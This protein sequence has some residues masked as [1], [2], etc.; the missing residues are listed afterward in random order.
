MKTT[1]ACFMAVGLGVVALACYARRP[2]EHPAADTSAAKAA[3]PITPVVAG[4]AVKPPA[5]LATA[6]VERGNLICT[7]PAKGT[8][9]LEEV[10]VG[11]QIT[12]MI[13]D[14]ATDPD[15]PGK[16]VDCGSRVRK[17]MVLAHIDPTIYQAQVD[18]AEAALLAAKANLDQL[19]AH[20][21][22][23]EQ[24]W[25][26]AKS[27]LPLRAIAD[28]DYDL[29][30]S[31]FRTAEANVVAGEAAVREN[32]ASLRI[33][34]TNF[35]YTVI[36][37]PSDG[38]IIDR[39]VNVGQTVVASFNAPGL[40]LIAKDS[41]QVQVWASVD[42][43]DIG[44]IRPGA[45]VRFTLS[46]CA[47]ESFEGKVAQVRL[48]PTKQGD[49]V[50][51]TV[52]VSAD[53]FGSMLPDMTANLQFEVERRFNVLL[54]PNDA[55]KRLPPSAQPAADAHATSLADGSPSPAKKASP[56]PKMP[57]PPKMAKFS[58]ERK[59]NRHLWVKEGGSVRHIDVQLGASNG[60]MTEVTGKNVREGMEVI[61]AAVCL[62]D[63]H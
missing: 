36:K 61:L 22:Q 29:V 58:K 41:R 13:A 49:A 12:G 9:K 44:Y 14:F 2:A 28:T 8:V 42:E 18:Y 52:V 24:E 19:K 16:P 1:F 62:N 37:S 35:D 48:S 32:E 53:N 43:A 45:P 26:R 3:Q 11:A 63:G 34:K 56:S 23:T 15:N 30:V 59:V 21:Q 25:K 6:K 10:E 4:A 55:L 20:C 38:V 47:D 31:N 50:K 40:F 7:V 39:R 17:G 46:A 51:Y 33:A 57:G 5:P 54:L 60:S 27:L